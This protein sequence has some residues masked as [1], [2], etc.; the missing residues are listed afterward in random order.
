MSDLPPDVPGACTSRPPVAP[1]SRGTTIPRFMKILCCG[2]TFPTA[3][4]MMQ[5]RLP[6]DQLVVCHH[7]AIRDA[8]D[9]VD[10]VVPLM[11]RIDRTLIEAGRFRLIQAH[12]AVRDRPR[13]RRHGRG[14]RPRRLGRQRSRQRGR[15]RRV[16]RRTCAVADAGG[17]P[18]AA[19]RPGER[20]RRRAG[21]PPRRRA[22]RPHGLHCGSGRGGTGGGSAV[23]TV[24]RA[25]D[26]RNA[27][28]R[29]RARPPSASPTATDSTNG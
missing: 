5:E 13:R 14:A 20:P 24:W 10:V 3:R 22:H 25:P 4:A 28:S 18:P 2:E 27:A 17:A 15:E 23:C 26:W 16:G 11:A 12:P 8:L 1:V 9:G 19:A 21:C 29:T 6:L 7:A